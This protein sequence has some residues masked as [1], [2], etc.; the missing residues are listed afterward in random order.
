VIDT[1]TLGEESRKRESEIHWIKKPTDTNYNKLVL[2]IR[3]NHKNELTLMAID[4][5]HEK[6]D[7]NFSD[8][9]LG[10]KAHGKS[11]LSS[12]V[13][14]GVKFYKLETQMHVPPNISYTI[15]NLRSPYNGMIFKISYAYDDKDVAAKFENMLVTSHFDR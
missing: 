9:D 13:Y 8:Y 12:V 14:G 1:A 10:L 4:S 5:I 3:D 2:L 6:L 15:I 11:V 7:F